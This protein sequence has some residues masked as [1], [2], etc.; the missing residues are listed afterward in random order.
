MTV[1]HEAV[2][3]R[4]KILGA[5]I[6]DARIASDKDEDTCAKAIG[7]PAHRFRAYEL[8]EESP[9]LPELEC[10]AYYLDVPMEHFWEKQPLRSKNG[11]KELKDI[12]RLMGLRQRMIGALLRQARIEADVSLE[13]LADYMQVEISEL[14]AYEL[15]ESSVPLPYLEILSGVLNR[16][17]REFHDQHGPVGRWQLS[18]Q[19]MQDFQEMPLDM[20]VFI[21]K[22]VNR[23][24]LDLAIRLS[25]MSV[26][27]LRAV[28]E[29][30][31]EITY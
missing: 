10:L 28:A 9:S 1:D 5:L 12:Q 4:A 31:L 29:G 19:A 11:R 17:I 2:T 25:D 30:L 15:G 14:E 27:R 20:Q 26:E 7:V 13:K 8:G 18:H 23:P 3:L 6:K 24:Y 21:S 22:P 16:S